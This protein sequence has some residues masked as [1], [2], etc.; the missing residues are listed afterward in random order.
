MK[1]IRI[2]LLLVVLALLA[3]GLFYESHYVESMDGTDKTMVNGPDFIKGATS[4]RYLR[5]GD[6]LI[7]RV[8]AVKK[9]SDAATID[10]CPT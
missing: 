2:I 1:P 7:D 5:R 8:S 4:D 3:Y 10:D 6:R 9:D